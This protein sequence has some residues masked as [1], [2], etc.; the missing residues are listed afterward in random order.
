MRQ[1]LQLPAGLSTQYLRFL[2]PKAIPLTV[3]KI[4]N[5]S[6]WI[7]G[8]RRWAG[9]EWR[10]QTLRQQRTSLPKVHQPEA[11]EPEAYRPEA[12]QPAVYQPEALEKH[13]GLLPCDHCWTDAGFSQTLGCPSFFWALAYFMFA[14]ESRRGRTSRVQVQL[15]TQYEK[16]AEL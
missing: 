8:L 7:V 5:L 14:Q 11:Y 10:P 13:S 4:R 2:V 9:P 3:F 15:G 16:P 12:H 1:R 6:Y